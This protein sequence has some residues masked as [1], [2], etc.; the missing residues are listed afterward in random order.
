[1]KLL[2]A[3]ERRVFYS[4]CA[5][6]LIFF[7]RFK[8][9]ELFFRINHCKKST[10]THKMTT[11][12]ERKTDFIPGY[13]IWF[14]DQNN[15]KKSRNRINSVCNWF[16]IV[17]TDQSASHL[18]RNLST[19]RMNAVAATA[20]TDTDA[21][22]YINVNAFAFAFRC[23]MLVGVTHNR[24]NHKFSF[25]L[26]R[27]E[28]TMHQKAAI[29][30]VFTDSTDRKNFVFDLK[31]LIELPTRKIRFSS[32]NGRSKNR[33]FSTRE[34]SPFMRLFPLWSF[35]LLLFQMRNLSAKISVLKR[36]IE[37]NREIDGDFIQRARFSIVIV[38]N[39]KI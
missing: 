21:N 38:M 8:L 3:S 24:W 4:S 16:S 7:C 11:E 32:S 26:Q 31:R 10:H 29:H 23:G 9:P 27:F 19:H 22:G 18:I 33:N 5:T 39:L 37:L 17:C 35:F 6:A 30:I 36:S 1:M 14:H 34:I 28:R 12:R 25:A 15:N 2:R 20:A 13:V